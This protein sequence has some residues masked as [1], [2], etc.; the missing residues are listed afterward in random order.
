MARLLQNIDA[1]AAVTSVYALQDLRERIRQ[2][3]KSSSVRS[4]HLRDELHFLDHDVQQALDTYVPNL[5]RAFFDYT[6][7]ACAGEA[8]HAATKC[9]VHWYG[10]KDS[11]WQRRTLWEEALAYNPRDLLV[12]C[13]KLFEEEWRSENYGG[14]AWARIA[15]TGQL[16][17]QVPDL[18][19][20]DLCVDLSHNSG[21]Y[22]DK[23]VIFYLSCVDHYRWVLDTKFRG[24]LLDYDKSCAYPFFAI[25]T[26][27]VLPDVRE[28][29]QAGA[30]L[31]L[32]PRPLSTIVS[33]WTS[34]DDT[35]MVVWGNEAFRPEVIT[36]DED[37]EDE[38]EQEDEEYEE[39]YEEEE[40]EE[41]E[42][43]DEDCYCCATEATDEEKENKEDNLAYF[44]TPT[45]RAA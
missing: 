33:R 2:E 17:G 30:L 39:E 1:T 21:N 5:A 23:G 15:R 10:Y 4:W 35:D 32:F 20:I 43:E 14:D 31:Y 28:V 41:E 13:E 38:E 6:A 22:L 9:S 29:L 27:Y 25:P 45:Q 26:L 18:V 24:K 12:E 16:Y 37:E 40:E 3:V 42:E 8:R 36:S 11:G 7:L 34:L 19:F 44:W